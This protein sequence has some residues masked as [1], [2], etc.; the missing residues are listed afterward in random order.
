MVGM[1]PGVFRNWAFVMDG[2]GATVHS[3][4]G[5]EAWTAMG[6][7]VIRHFE[8]DRRGVVF[9]P[10]PLPKDFQALCPSFE[11]AVAEEAAKPRGLGSCKDER[12]GLWSQYSLSS[13]R[14]PLSRGS[15][16]MVIEFLKLDSIQR[17]NQGR[18]EGSEIEPKDEDSAIEK[19]FRAFI[20]TEE[21]V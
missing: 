15:G 8:W 14:A 21:V 13:I 10:S 19:D 6:E 7:Y 5:F 1:H 12:F 18:E 16:C 3:C 4:T 9:L 11:L 20:F 17:L 2:P